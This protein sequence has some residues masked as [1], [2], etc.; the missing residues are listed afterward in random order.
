MAPMASHMRC[1]PSFRK[2]E[3]GGRDGGSIGGGGKGGSGGGAG[4]GDG[5]GGPCLI[6]MQLRWLEVDA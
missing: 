5:G 2:G 3:F 6:C 4:E 1:G